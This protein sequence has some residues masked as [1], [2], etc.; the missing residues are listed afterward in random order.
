M[1][2]ICFQGEIRQIV[3]PVVQE[4]FP[5]LKLAVTSSRNN[6]GNRVYYLINISLWTQYYRIAG[7]LSLFMRRCNPGAKGVPKHGN[8]RHSGQNHPQIWDCIDAVPPYVLGGHNL[9]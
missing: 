6:F 1:Q 9:L 8:N 2:C 3:Q 5:N 7:R 4:L